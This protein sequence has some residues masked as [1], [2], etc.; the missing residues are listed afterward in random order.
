M[1][2]FVAQKLKNNTYMLLRLSIF[3]FCTHHVND[4]NKYSWIKTIRVENNF[5][6][7]KTGFKYLD[8]V[9]RY[10]AQAEIGLM[11]SLFYK[12]YAILPPPESHLSGQCPPSHSQRV[13]CQTNVHPPT[14]ESHPSDQCPLPHPR[15]S[16]L[17]PMSILPPQ[18]VTPQT[19]VHCPIL[20]SHPSDQCPSQ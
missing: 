15:E 13:I 9:C 20:E 11:F 12:Q 16:P 8:S 10:V 17:R 5:S 4:K 2:N 18:R 14:P 7:F 19:N 1:H 6:M 3:L